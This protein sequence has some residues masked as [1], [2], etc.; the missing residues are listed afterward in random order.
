MKDTMTINVG[1]VAPDFELPVHTGGTF[2]LNDHKGKSPVVLYFYPKDFTMNCTK[3]ACSFR[4]GYDDIQKHGAQLIGISR[5]D[6]ESHKKFAR[7][8]RLN[9]PLAS[10]VSYEVCRKYGVLW[11]GGIRIKRLTFLVDK[12]GIV[13]GKF[14][15]EVLIDRHLENVLQTLREIKSPS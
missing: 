1:D 12:A 10:D 3:E 4:N 8:H 5:D 2:R 15:H 7:L 9:F 11:L 13:R 14:S 6:V